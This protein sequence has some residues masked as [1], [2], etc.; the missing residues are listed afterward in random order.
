[1]VSAVRSVLVQKP[2]LSAARGRLRQIGR[3]A[4]HYSKSAR[5]LVRTGAL[6]QAL[7]DTRV[8]GLAP[9]GLRKLRTVVGASLDGAKPGRCLQTLLARELSRALLIQ[10]A[11][12][13]S[14][15]SAKGVRS[16]LLS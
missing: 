3:F 9:A 14:L 8:Y 1:M 12:V 2:R 5:K 10:L 13:S 16:T 11:S 6:P 4:K 15:V 7:Y